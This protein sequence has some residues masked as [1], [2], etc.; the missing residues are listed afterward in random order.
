MLGVRIEGREI[1]A[2]RQ[3]CQYLT[4]GYCFNTDKPFIDG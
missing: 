2:R 3:R 4:S 1:E